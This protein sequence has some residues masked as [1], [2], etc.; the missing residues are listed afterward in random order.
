MKK[1]M[2]MGMAL[3]S[4]GF[5][6]IACS[7]DTIYD[8]NFTSKEKV[9]EYQKAFEQAFGKIAVGNDWGFGATTVT[10]A[11][12][13]D[14]FNQ[15]DVSGLHKPING[16]KKVAAFIE[17]FNK[18]SVAT[19]VDFSDYFLQHVIKQTGNG[20]KGW[21]TS[22][23]HHQLAQLQAFNYN[24]NQWENVEYFT[25]GKSE[26]QFIQG[27]NNTHGTTLMVNMGTPNTSVSPQFRW[28]ASGNAN[29][30]SDY[31][32][33]NYVIKKVDGEYFL[34]MSYVNKPANASNDATQPYNNYDAWIIRLVKAVGD[35]G[36]K[37]YGRVM[38][39]DLGS[40]QASDLDFNDIVFDAYILNDGSIN[41]TILA[42]GGMLRPV[43]VAGVEVN[44][45]QMSNTD[46]NDITD[47]IQEFTISAAE[48]KRVDA[49][50]GK[51]AWTSIKDIPVVVTAADGTK[52]TLEAK[53]D[54]SAPAKVCTYVG[55]RWAKEKT[56]LNEA[57]SN[58]TT[59]VNT[60]DPKVW[61]NNMDPSKV[62]SP[63]FDVTE[64]VTP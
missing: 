20:N 49:S 23:T 2:F 14:G 47:N 42:A 21:G 38:C 43:T 30:G 19:D 18:A 5:A 31:V 15:Y 26:K 45:K 33:T 36:Y 11:S 27:N 32:C 57:Y 17:K 61:F 37:E 51:K 62:V 13:T 4:M 52:I 22:D 7:H 60:T 16:N 39:E 64:I 59:Y 6:F 25:G 1:T 10:R 12:A 34:G 55:V 8:E 3:L 9:A 53:S 50:T 58:W 63:F 41:I 28:L 56:K 29:V 54:G 40:T 48:A 46:Y 35:P 44:L 24:T